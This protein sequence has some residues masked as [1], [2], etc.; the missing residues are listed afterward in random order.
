MTDKIPG[1][2]I[3]ACVINITII[4]HTQLQDGGHQEKFKSYDDG[5]EW[6][7]TE[8]GVLEPVWSCGAAVPNSLVNL[9]D[10]GDREE[11]KGEEEENH[12]KLRRGS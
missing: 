3:L 5:Q 12:E 7:R 9:L 2:D 1:G 10:T 4:Q 8:D 11:E 6:I